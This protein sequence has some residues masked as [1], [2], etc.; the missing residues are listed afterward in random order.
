MILYPISAA[1]GEGVRDLLDRVVQI[2]DQIGEEPAV[3]EKEYFIEEQE[4]LQALKE[5]DGDGIDIEQL[6][7]G[8]Y[9][10][11]GPAIEKMLGFT[12]LESEKGFDF[13][14]RS[15]TRARRNCPPGRDG[16]SRRGYRTGG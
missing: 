12:H 10:V 14:Q 11:G 7:D 13:F 3:F 6:P 2:R 15:P 5:N 4:A 1:T 8:T 16:D 9:V